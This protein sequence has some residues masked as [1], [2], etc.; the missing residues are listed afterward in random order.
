LVTVRDGG[1]TLKWGPPETD[2][3]SPVIDYEVLTIPRTSPTT[4]V[5]TRVTVTGLTNDSIYAF[6]V[7]ARNSVGSSA[8]PEEAVGPAVPQRMEVE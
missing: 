2:G 6:T 4:T 7:T 1:V 3:G 8:M 5:D